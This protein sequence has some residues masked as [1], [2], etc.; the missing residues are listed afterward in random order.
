MAKPAGLYLARVF[1]GEPTWLDPVLRPV[2]GVIHAILGVR[3]EREM[4]AGAIKT[5]RRCAKL[6]VVGP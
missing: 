4:S 1:E 6:G 2:E 3:R 5:P